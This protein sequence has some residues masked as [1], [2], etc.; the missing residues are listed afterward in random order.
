MEEEVPMRAL[1]GSAV[2][3]D[4]NVTPLIDVCL[5]LLIIFMIVLPTM[6][7]GADV[8]LPETSVKNPVDARVFPVTMKED[9][10]V[11]LDTL[12]VR[13]EEVLSSLQRMRAKE[14]TRPIAVRADKRV[15]YGEVATVLSACREA[16]WSDVALV[17]VEPQL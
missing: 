2:Q 5:V 7:N 16:G 9:G 14:S 6:V 10:T 8:K 11:Y 3:S 17:G 13:R 15:L 12:V 4:I 1:R